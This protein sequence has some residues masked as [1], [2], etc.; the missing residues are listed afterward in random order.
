[1]KISHHKS[2][3]KLTEKREHVGDSIFVCNT[4]V[5]H[6]LQQLFGAQSRTRVVARGAK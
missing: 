2:G 3:Y 6:A 4:L 5:G 1:M